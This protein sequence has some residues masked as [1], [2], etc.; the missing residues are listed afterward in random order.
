[1]RALAFPKPQRCKC[2]TG[3]F[4]LCGRRRHYTTADGT[5]NLSAHSSASYA[6]TVK[7]PGNRRRLLISVTLGIFAIGS[8]M[9]SSRT[10][11]LWF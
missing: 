7:T 5:L 9:V 8:V 10:T 1:M 2:I 6:D 11:W 3:R 4:A